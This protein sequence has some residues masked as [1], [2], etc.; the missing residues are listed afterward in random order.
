MDLDYI[1][2]ENAADAAEQAS[3]DAWVTQ[4]NAEYDAEHGALPGQ[5]NHSDDIPF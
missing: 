4:A 5:P 1:D 2:L 3:I